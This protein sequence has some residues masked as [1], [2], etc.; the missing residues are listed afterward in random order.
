LLVFA[1]RDHLI[2]DAAV[3]L[4]EKIFGLEI[5]D[6]GVESVIIEQNGAQDGAFGVEILR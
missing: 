5:F 6:G 3:L 4:Q 1:E 2:E